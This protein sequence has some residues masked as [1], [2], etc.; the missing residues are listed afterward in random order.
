MQ[1]RIIGMICA[2]VLISLNA[3]AGPQSRAKK[4]TAQ[5]NRKQVTLTLVRWPYT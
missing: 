4:T 3:A 2:L 1:K 5:D